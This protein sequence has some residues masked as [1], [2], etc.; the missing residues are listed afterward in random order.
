MG[1]DEP[2]NMTRTAIAQVSTVVPVLERQQP[3]P[4]RRQKSRR[5]ERISTTTAVQPAS[6]KPAPLTLAIDQVTVGRRVA[7]KNPLREQVDDSLPEPE[8]A[9]WRTLTLQMHKADGQRLDI[10]LLRPVDWTETHRAQAGITTITS[11]TNRGPPEPVYNLEVHREHVYQVATSGVLVHNTYPGKFP[12]N[13]DDLLPDLPRDAK[14]RIYPSDRI[15][16]R[17]EQHALEPGETY[18][19]RHH[20]Q[21]YHVEVRIDP[22]KSFN[23][24]K[25][26]IKLKPSGYKPGDGAGFL[27]GEVF[28]DSY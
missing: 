25:N 9:T 26:V 2:I 4:S 18:A 10:V 5:S 22:S 17:P 16:I 27:P 1:V 6:F 8:E 20:G 28:P 15:R 19:P 13:P 21:H 24:K 23:N 11:I 14:G 3:H 12:D 7:G